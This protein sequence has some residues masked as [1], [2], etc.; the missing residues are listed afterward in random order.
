MVRQTPFALPTYGVDKMWLAV[1]KLC[2][3]FGVYDSIGSPEFDWSGYVV[4][5]EYHLTGTDQMLVISTFLN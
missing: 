4:P 5:E 3:E 1:E 2:I